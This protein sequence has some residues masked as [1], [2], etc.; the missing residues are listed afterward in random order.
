[1]LG[2]NVHGEGDDWYEDSWPSKAQW[3]R[4]YFGAPWRSS[5]HLIAEYRFTTNPDTRSFP[6]TSEDVE[7]EPAESDEAEIDEA[8]SDE[9]E[10]DEDQM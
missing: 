2:N 9:A 6:W 5:S 4:D 10:I 1:M 8:E 3:N 7:L